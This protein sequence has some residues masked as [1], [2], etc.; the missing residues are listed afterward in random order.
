MT[1]FFRKRFN[2]FDGFCIGWAVQFTITG[3]SWF[4]VI[5]I[6]FAAAL[7]SSLAE[8]KLNLKD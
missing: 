8:E 4:I 5:P 2:W 6:I 1:L 7:F 3:G